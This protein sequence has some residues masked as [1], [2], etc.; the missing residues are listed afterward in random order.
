M[1]LISNY[2]PNCY[3]NLLFQG[4]NTKKLISKLESAS[5]LKKIEVTFD[6]L[7]RMYNEIGYD[8]IKKRGS[9]TSV[10]VNDD[11]AITVVI[12][13]GEKYVHANDL[14]RFLLVK[15]GKFIEATKV[16]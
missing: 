14:K 12:P 1:Y 13:H 5:N 11:I 9:H 2:I 4:G 10:K 3:S 8:V 16:H 15:E 7:E 6:Q